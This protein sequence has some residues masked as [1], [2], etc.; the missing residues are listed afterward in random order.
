LG[1]VVK[2][3]LLSIQPQQPQQQRTGR[4][5]KWDRIGHQ[6]D[7]LVAKNVV[8]PTVLMNGRSTMSYQLLQPIC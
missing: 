3:D 7:T 8:T 6:I 5:A 2:L 1:P 4:D